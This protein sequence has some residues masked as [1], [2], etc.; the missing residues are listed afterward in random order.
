MLKMMKICSDKCVH[1]IFDQITYCALFYCST[2]V[3]LELFKSYCT[4]FYCC[5]LWTAY[6][7]STFDW[8]PVAFNSAYHRVVSQLWRCSAN[9]MYANF[10]INIFEATIRKST[11]GL[12]QR[13][14]KSTN[15]LIVTIEKS[16]IV[17]IEIWNF[18]QNTFYIAAAT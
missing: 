18:W 7:K 9:A 14:A 15:S 1:C 2:D 6:K 10:S 12:I 8:L 16:W 11:F 3:E 13:L 4:S 5:Y 17:R